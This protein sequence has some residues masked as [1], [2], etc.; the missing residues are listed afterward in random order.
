[1]SEP[2]VISSRENA[3]LKELRKLSTDNT[4]YR[5]AGRFWIEGDHLCSAALARGVVPSVMVAS[6]SFVPLAPVEYARAAIKI[7]VIP[8]ALFREISGLESPATGCRMPAMWG[9]SS[10][11]P[12]LSVS[13]RCSRSK[14]QPHSGAPRSC[15]Q[16]WARTLAFD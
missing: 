12:E 1:M 10:V 15:G 13:V 4:A 6:E 8:D 16:G 11:A 3:L 2:I 9:P 7:V 14:D 5:K